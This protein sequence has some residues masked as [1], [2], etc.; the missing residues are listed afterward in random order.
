MII[1]KFN[2]GGLLK[3]SKFPAKFTNLSA[4]EQL[5]EYMLS[6][7]AD[8]IMPPTPVYKNEQVMWQD[9]A[10]TIPVTSVWQPVGS[11]KNLG[12]L[13]GYFEQSTD[14]NFRPTLTVLGLSS[15]G[16]NDRLRLTLPTLAQPFTMLTYINTLQN[17][18]GYLYDSR[19]TGGSTNNALIRQS[20]T[21]GI[22]NGG[23]SPQLDVSV[24]S[25][26]GQR[27][28]FLNEYN[29]PNN[30]IAMAGDVT[31]TNTGA[32]DSN[33]GMTDGVT[34]FSN[35]N[36]TSFC[37]YT[38]KIF[39][40]FPKILSTGE[41]A[42]LLTQ[43]DVANP[44]NIVD[45]YVGD[46]IN[47]GA[48]VVTSKYPTY[49]GE[50]VMWQDTAR[51]IPVVAF[52]QPVGSVKNLGS[53]G[54]YFEA[55]GSVRPLMTINGLS[56]DG[57]DDRMVLSLANLV[58]PYSNILWSSFSALAAPATVIPVD[59]ATA[60][61]DLRSTMERTR[62]ATPESFLRIR[63]GATTPELETDIVTTAAIKVRWAGVWNGLDSIQKVD[64]DVTVNQTGT[65]TARDMQGGVVLGSDRGS[66][67][68][69]QMSL[70]IYARFP[71]ALTTGQIDSLPTINQVI[72]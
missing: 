31:G 64:G 5:V 14:N 55:S 47:A 57:V 19:G 27:L 48:D 2:I 61:A 25:S 3:G 16:V 72:P 34:V 56:F 67:S 59:Q 24:S 46:I 71:S 52:G 60:G 45:D 4:L 15:D 38:N 28:R 35:R 66:A 10:R 22:R 43:L 63:S 1:D 58:S 29:Q 62:T 12:S 65:L 30:T 40:R 6:I 18:T 70:G 49:R 68:F 51:Q 9:V 36:V 26:A 39:A 13:G 37:S 32:L 20:A 33:V 11:V 42:G 41:K 21:M 7:G 44:D 53:A 50:Q 23:N 54:G 8:V 69:T 17:Q